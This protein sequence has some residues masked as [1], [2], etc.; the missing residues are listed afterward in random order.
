MRRPVLAA[1]LT[2]LTLFAGCSGGGTEDAPPERTPAERLDAARVALEGAGS[3]A[4]DLTSED[5][6]PQENGVTAA[7]GSG[8]VDATEPRFQGTITGTV[9][10]VAATVDVI[11]VGDDA[12]LKLFTPDYEPFDLSTL[13]APNPADFFD[14]ADGIASLLPQTADPTVDGRVRAGKEV[15]LQ[16]SG[17]IPAEPVDTLFHIGEGEGTYRV[18]YGLTDDD[19][20]RTATLV[21]PFFGTEDSTYRLTLTDYGAPVEISRP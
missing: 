7:R 19:Q 11:A 13:N 21:G 4:L 12:Y 1:A 9:R 18:S 2:A 5:V 6:P 17:T 3:V 14:P 15:L 16:V 8:V 20:L 10:G